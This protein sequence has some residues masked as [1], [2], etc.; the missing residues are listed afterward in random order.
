M[1]LVH[2]ILRS[3]ILLK[4]HGGAR[5]M[6]AVKPCSQDRFDELMAYEWGDKKLNEVL[7]SAFLKDKERAWYE[8]DNNFGVVTDDL[9][10]PECHYFL[11]DKPTI[12]SRKSSELQ[13]K[14]L[15]FRNAKEASTALI[16]RM[17][18]LE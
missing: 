5:R 4:H 9:F 16:A 14:K 10:D 15:G 7:R 12:H 6:F 8:S 13:E 1:I 17:K 2:R 3:S 11:L 18:E